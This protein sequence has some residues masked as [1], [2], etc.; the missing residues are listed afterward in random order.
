MA[1]IKPKHGIVGFF[2]ILGYTNFLENNDAQ[3]AATVIVDVLTKLHEK[4]PKL[5]TEVFQHTAEEFRKPLDRVEWLVFSDTILVVLPW[6]KAE[7]DRYRFNE[8]VAFTMIAQIL[9]RMMFD[10]GL[11]LR[12]AITT[13]DF[14]LEGNCFAGKSIIEAHHLSES[15]DLA[16]TA[17]SRGAAQDMQVLFKKNGYSPHHLFQEYLLPLKGQSH[18]KHLVLSPTPCVKPFQGDIPQLVAET[19]WRHNKDVPVNV[20]PKLKNTEM[21]FRFLKMKHA[22][23]FGDKDASTA[24]P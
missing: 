6:S 1:T 15:L 8:W 10:Y 3:D 7:V 2:D 20:V 12:G 11:P 16:A 17:L 24:S 5:A 23:I 19:F 22:H 14:V 13:G 4:V 18:A 21:L 9:S